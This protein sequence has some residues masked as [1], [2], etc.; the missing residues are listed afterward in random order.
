M[1]RAAVLDGAVDCAGTWRALGAWLALVPSAAG[2]GAAASR[3]AFGRAKALGPDCQLTPVREAEALAVLLQDRALFDRLL[4]GVL[5]F[6][7]ARAPQWAPENELAKRAA[8]DLLARR[9]RLF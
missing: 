9:D 2:G 1:E 3:A 8:R 7:P 4:G 5:A 6:D